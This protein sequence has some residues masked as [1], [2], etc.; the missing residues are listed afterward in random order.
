[1]T[2]DQVKTLVSNTS[3]FALYPWDGT[4]IMVRKGPHVFYVILQNMTTDIY[5]GHVE[6]WTNKEEALAN[7][8]CLA[9]I[10]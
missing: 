8:A 1:M 9:S 5:D 6:T 10:T 4:N 2:Q 7:A 3:L